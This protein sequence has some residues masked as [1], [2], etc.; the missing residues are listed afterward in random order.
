VQG[1]GVFGCYRWFLAT[2]VVM[3]HLAPVEYSAC[4]YY[5]V[6]GFFCLS[7]Y[8]MTYV[9]KDH[10]LL[11]PKGLRRYLA[12]RAL[13]IYP[14]YWLVAAFGFAMIYWLPDIAKEVHPFMVMPDHPLHWFANSTLFGIILAYG[15]RIES[16]FVPPA[17]SLSIE[18]V[19]YLLLPFVVRNGFLWVWW[20][21]MCLAFTAAHLIEGQGFYVRY[22]SYTGGMMPF[23]LG[24]ALYLFKDNL[25]AL[26]H[27]AGIP[28]LVA[29]AILNIFSWPIMGE[30]VLQEGFYIMFALNLLAIHYLSRIVI[31]KQTRFE[32]IDA[33][34]GG[35]AYPIFLVHVPLAVAIKSG[36][37]AGMTVKTFPFFFLCLPFVYAISWL[38]H[39]VLEKRINPL[40]AHIRSAV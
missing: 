12:N 28:L 32:R 6:F 20:I 24:S 39:I 5:A 34:L 30:H 21:G 4:G 26:P 27:V 7:G 29:L 15:I 9:L 18:M 23:A 1:T 22:F 19:M 11:Q 17:W 13:R 31:N 10:Y 16:I 8:L 2:M 37:A 25:P 35:M 38:L 36:I 14:I 40:R 3:S 33:L